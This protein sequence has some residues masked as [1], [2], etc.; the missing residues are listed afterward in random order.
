MS[1]IEAEMDFKIGPGTFYAAIAKLLE[2]GLIRRIPGEERVKIYEITGDGRDAVA[3]FLTRWSGVI[4][5]GES[6]LA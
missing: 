3:D 1:D 5:L 4:R 6:R 2:G